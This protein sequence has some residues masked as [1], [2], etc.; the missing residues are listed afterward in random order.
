MTI[1]SKMFNVENNRSVINEGLIDW[2]GEGQLSVRQIP[3]IVTAH[4]LKC[5]FPYFHV[6]YKSCAQI[7]IP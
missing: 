1:S 6:I 7:K 2:R 5:L 4:A 3:P